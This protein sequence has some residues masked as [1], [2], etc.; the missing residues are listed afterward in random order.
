[1]R[2]FLTLLML[3]A[4]FAL[5]ARDGIP[6][7]T[8]PPTPAEIAAFFGGGADQARR[9]AFD[10]Q[11]ILLAPDRRIAIIDGQRLRV[12]DRLE[13]AKVTAIEPGRV[14]LDRAGETIELRI[15]THLDDNHERSRD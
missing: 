15:D 7:P 12:G 3:A 1:M 2:K 4:P 14:L 10:L 6:D 8:R 9:P 5:Q 13:S 11:S